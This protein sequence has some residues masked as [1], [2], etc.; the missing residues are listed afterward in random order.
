MTTVNDLPFQYLLRSSFVERLHGEAKASALEERDRELEDFL[1]SAGGGEPGPTGPQGPAGPKG[2][3]GAQGAQGA[4]GNTGAQGAQGIQGTQGVP[5]SQGPAGPG[6]ATG[7]T[8]GQALTKIDATNYNTQWTTVATADF[9]DR[10]MLA[11]GTDWNTVTTPGRYWINGLSTY[12]NCPIGGINGLLEVLSATSNAGVCVWQRLTFPSGVLPPYTRSFSP[13]PGWLG[14]TS[15]PGGIIAWKRGSV[16]GAWFTGAAELNRLTNVP[17]YVGRMYELFFTVRAMKPVTAGQACTGVFGHGA[18]TTAGT[19]L[20]LAYNHAVPANN[21]WL[22]ATVSA[23]FSPSAV[24]SATLAI[25]LSGSG[26]GMVTYHDGQDQFTVRD[27]G[28]LQGGQ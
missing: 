22:G 4:Q 10:G 25:D 11:N 14:W 8:A 20:N 5:G 12:P 2:D 24:P 21:D 15:P 17:L 6:V 23:I 18:A 13:S 16:S 9:I 3:T 19:G 28:I 27:L 26:T 7:G 1:S